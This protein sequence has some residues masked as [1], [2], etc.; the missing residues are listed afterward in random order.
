V[1]N[2][3]LKLKFDAP[4]EVYMDT[5]Q[6]SVGAAALDSLGG[7]LSFPVLGDNLNRDEIRVLYW[8]QVPSQ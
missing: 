7:N 4:V 3:E 5:D 1:T 2:T 8:K 6:I